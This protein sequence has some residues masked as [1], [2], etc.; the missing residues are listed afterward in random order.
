M[1]GMLW[2]GLNTFF[3]GPKCP[4]SDPCIEETPASIWRYSLPLWFASGFLGTRNVHPFRTPRPH[5]PKFVKI[6]AFL[7]L[8]PGK[9]RKKAQKPSNLAYP[10]FLSQQDTTVR[11]KT[12]T[13]SLVTLENLFTPNYRYRYRHEIRTNFHYRYRLGVRSHPFISIDFQLPS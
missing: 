11:V 6:S 12:I 2:G 10:L 5:H 1:R 3:S 9:F 8:L 4:P 13:G 7:S